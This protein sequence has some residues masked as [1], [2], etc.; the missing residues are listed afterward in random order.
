MRAQGL[1]WKSWGRIEDPERDRKSIVSPTG[2]INL[3]PWELSENEQP[4]EE[5]TR[6][7][8]RL[9]P[10][11]HTH[12]ADM[13]LGIHVGLPTNGAGAVPEAVVCLWLTG[14]S[15]L[16]SAGEDAPSSTET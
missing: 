4:T 14:F 9:L 8:S 5:H 2:P 10:E 3:D 7:G 16:T 11:L 12:V 13:Q 6:A 15:C 1:L